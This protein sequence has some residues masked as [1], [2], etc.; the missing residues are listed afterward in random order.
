MDDYL[1]KP[2][3]AADLLAAIER[4]VLAQRV[5][6]PPQAGSDGEMNL[7]DPVVLLAACGDDAEGLRGLCEDFQEFLP[8]RSAEI[9]E[10]VKQQDARRLRDAAHKFCGLVSAFSTVAG[11]VA[12]ELEDHAANGRLAEARALVWRLLV[13]AEELTRQVDGL[14]LERLRSA[15]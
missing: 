8:A 10:A 9:A 2:V 11:Q 4:A 1:S 6:D 12:A 14:S 7:L 13:I 5:S 3:R 15:L